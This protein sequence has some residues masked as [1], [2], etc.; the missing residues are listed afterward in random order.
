MDNSCKP[1]RIFRNQQLNLKSFP[2]QNKQTKIMYQTSIINFAKYL[3][4]G[5]KLQNLP[6]NRYKER[7]SKS[8]Y[9]A[10]SPDKEI[11]LKNE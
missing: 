5:E 1:I 3:R 11:I 7:F 2:H 6:E 4:G 10:K 8:F 9:E